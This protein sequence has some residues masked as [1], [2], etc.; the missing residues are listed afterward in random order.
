MIVG[1]VSF[2]LILCNGII[3]GK[4]DPGIEVGL[5]IGWFVGLLGVG[6]PPGS[7]VSAPG[8]LHDRAKAAGRHLS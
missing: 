2:M 7:R 6:R 1:I 3:L 4:P 5:G 8:R